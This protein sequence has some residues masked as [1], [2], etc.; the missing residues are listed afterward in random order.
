MDRSTGN[1]L[2]ALARWKF[3]KNGPRS[4]NWKT[5]TINLGGLPP[6]K[7]DSGGSDDSGDGNGSDGGDGDGDGD[8]DDNS[9]GNRRD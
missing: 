3:L 2:L 6:G 5:T 9:E 7:D 8:Y 4:Y 1:R